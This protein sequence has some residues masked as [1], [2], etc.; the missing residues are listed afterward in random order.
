MLLAERFLMARLRNAKFTSL[1]EATAEIARLVTFI[2]NR[3]FKRPDATRASLFAELD[4]PALRP[5]PPTRHEFATWRR[6]KVNI[7]DHVAPRSERH[8]YSDSVPHRLVGE[9]VDLRCSDRVTS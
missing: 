8:F 9:R 7:D 4:R 6:A 5:L 3:R 2:N 1:E